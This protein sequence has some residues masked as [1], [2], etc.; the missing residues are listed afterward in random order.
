MVAGVVA[1][2][3]LKPFSP[4]LAERAMVRAM[5]ATNAAR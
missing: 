2:R 5:V 1:I 4:R 3:L